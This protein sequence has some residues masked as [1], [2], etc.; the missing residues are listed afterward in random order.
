[1]TKTK[2]ENLKQKSEDNSLLLQKSNAFSS[3]KIKQDYETV[4]YF[5]K[6]NGFSE[7]FITNLR[8]VKGFI[9]IN[10]QPS[11]TKSFLPKDSILS[12]CNNPNPK[13]T[14]MHCKLPLDIVYEDAYYLLVNKPSGISTMPNRSHYSENLGGAICHY[15]QNNQP[16]FTLRILNRLDKDTSG[17]VLVAKNSIAQKDIKNIEKTYL[18]ICEGKIDKSCT[19]SKP[20]LT[21]CENGVNL[22]KRVISE[23]GQEATTS[24]T[25]VKIMDECTLLS[26]K[27]Q[28]GRTHQIRVHLASIGHPLVGDQ[29]YGKISDKI[30]HAA[31]CCTELS[32]YHPYLKKKLCFTAPLPQDF[33][34]LTH[35]CV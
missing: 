2:S 4:Y 26:I 16:D 8:K 10:N 13:T 31:L 30:N 22:Q 7:N 21:I 18:A 12:I 27:L 1:M 33:L 32:F 29:L 14:I 23:K 35:S 34:M 20:I 5:L 17:L 15:L 9:L 11:T 19:I 6:D 24:I 25:P 28:H 3:Y